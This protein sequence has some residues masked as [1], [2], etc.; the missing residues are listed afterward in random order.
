MAIFKKFQRKKESKPKAEAPKT[1]NDSGETNFVLGKERILISAPHVTEKATDLG[2]KNQYTFRV[3]KNANKTEVK[4]AVENIYKVNVEA[5][6]I[7]NVRPKKRRLG[8]I[9]GRRKG[10]K[11]A[12]VKIKKG[13]EIELFPR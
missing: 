3:L 7:I 12:M 11:K 4:K 9:E 13:Q 6:K 5:I 1:I 8:R 10:Y 2:E